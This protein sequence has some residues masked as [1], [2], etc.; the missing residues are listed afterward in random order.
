M[1]E[2]IGYGGDSPA[3]MFRCLNNC[4]YPDEC[5]NCLEGKLSYNGQRRRHQG[6]NGGYKKA[7]PFVN[8][9]KTARELAN[10]YNVCPDTIREWAKKY[11]QEAANGGM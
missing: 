8:G 10:Q 5:R 6:R 9:E 1:D 11:K 2:L 3:D 7:L 4:P